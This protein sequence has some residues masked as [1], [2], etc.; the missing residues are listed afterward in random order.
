MKRSRCR[1]PHVD[2]IGFF[3]QDASSRGMAV[4]DAGPIVQIR[5]AWWC[6][7][8]GFWGQEPNGSSPITAAKSVNLAPET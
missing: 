8:G 4:D 3:D 5:S 1:N 2:D 6:L 7:G